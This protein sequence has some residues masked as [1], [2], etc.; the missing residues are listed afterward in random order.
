[1]T[2][3]LWDRGTGCSALEVLLQQDDLLSQGQVVLEGRMT[4]SSP[5]PACLPATGTT[6]S[7]CTHHGDHT[8]LLCQ[9]VCAV[10]L[11]KKAFLCDCQSFSWVIVTYFMGSHEAALFVLFEVVCQ[12]N[13]SHEIWTVPPHFFLYLF[14]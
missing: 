8:G 6:P 12:G 14:I 5:N 4:K 3:G 1:M 9:A 10:P 2:K 7:F 13:Q 11:C